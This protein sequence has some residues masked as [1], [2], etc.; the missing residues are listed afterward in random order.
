MACGLT[1]E[2]TDDRTGKQT[3]GHTNGRV[4]GVRANGRTDVRANGRT[5]EWENGRMI[6]QA[7]GR[8]G[9]QKDGRANGRT[10][11]WMNGRMSGPAKRGKF[12]RDVQTLV[13]DSVGYID[14]GFR[15]RATKLC[16]HCRSFFDEFSIRLLTFLITPVHRRGLGSIFVVYIGQIHPQGWKLICI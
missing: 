3:D 6:G 2:Q 1:G 15:L 5:G 12:I 4:N 9:V 7:N 13:M 16:P 10:D 14:L 8:T 11:A